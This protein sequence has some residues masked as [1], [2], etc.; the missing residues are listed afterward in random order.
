M[1]EWARKGQAHVKHWLFPSGA[2]RIRGHAVP[3]LGLGSEEQH[4]LVSTT[5]G[6]PSPGINSGRG[7][8]LLIGTWGLSFP[9]LV[10]GGS[11]A[12]DRGR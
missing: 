6:S 3:F 12:Q 9:T 10:C 7:P 5:R 8:G 1:G 4:F 2:P 11:P